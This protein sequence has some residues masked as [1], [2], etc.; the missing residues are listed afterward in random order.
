MLRP[1]QRLN[2]ATCYPPPGDADDLLDELIVGKPRDPRGLRKTGVHRRIGN[3]AGQGIQL[4]DVGHA[5][6]VEAHV[7]AAPVPAAQGAIR[8]ERDTLGLAAQRCRDAAGRAL[9][10]RER[11]L[12]RV[13]DPL[14]LVAVDGWGSGRQRGE[15]ESDDGEAAYVAVVAEY[16]DRELRSW[17]IGLDEHRLLVAR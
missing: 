13:P 17:E 14:R 16:R 7:D 6:A 1:Y 3:D 8:V 12:A 10:D 4:D 2:L 15:I 11:M 9:E 5:E